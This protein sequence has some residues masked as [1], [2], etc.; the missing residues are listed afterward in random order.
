MGQEIKQQKFIELR[1]EGI[2]LSKISNEIGISKPTLIKWTREL[3][4]E[5][6]NHKTLV[7]DD[8]RANFQAS[9]REVVEKL[10]KLTSRIDEEIANRDLSDVSTDKLIRLSLDLKKEIDLRTDVKFRLEDEESLN[11][12]DFK[13]CSEFYP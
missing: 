11:L 2:S 10:V 7:I 8:L 13:S 1:A 12:L 3:G 5:L 9:K 4:L 6:N